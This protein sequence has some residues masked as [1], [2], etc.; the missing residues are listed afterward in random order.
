MASHN[1]PIEL[2]RFIGREREIADVRR[3]LAGVASGPRLLTLTGVGGSGKTRLA[4]RVAITLASSFP[5]GVWLVE[6]A[7]LTEP[8]L[9]A[10]ALAATLG[11]REQAG[12]EGQPPLAQT[13]AVA[14]APKQLLLVLDNCEHLAGACA[15]LVETLLQS[16]PDLRILATSREPLRVPGEVTWPVPPLALPPTD[17]PLP[18]EDLA[19]VESVALFVD[20]ARARRPSFTLTL[21]NAPAIIAICR[22]LEGL[23]LA[24]ELAAAQIGALPPEQLA[25]RLEDPPWAPLHL[26][27]GGRRTVPRHETLR[28]TL[29]WSHA[30]LTD[31]ERTVF[32]RLAV[33][34]GGFPLE[35][36]EFVCSA[37]GISPADVCGVLTSLVDKSLLIAL[38]Q[39]SIARFR[40]L[41]PVRQYAWEQLRRSGEEVAV[42]RRHA[43]AFL[44]LAEAAAPHLRSGGRGPWLARLEAEHDNLRAA[45]TWTLAAPGHPTVAPD[46]SGAPT[47]ADRALGVRLAAAL[48]HFWFFR[49]YFP[50]GVSWITQA[51]AQPADLAP[52]AR[53]KALCIG[54]ELVWMLF[55]PSVQCWEWL[56]ESVALWRTLGD[57]PGLAYALQASATVNPDSEHAEE[58]AREGLELS[59]TLHDLAG[60]ALALHAMGLLAL[61][62][63]DWAAAAAHLTAA[64]ALYRQVGDDWYGAQVLNNL[65]DVA[66]IQ[67]DDVQAAALYRE[68]LALF[69]SQGVRSAIPS[70][71]Q[72]LGYLTLRTGD[73]RR[74]R[75]LF[76]ESIGMFRDQAD[77]RGTAESLAGLAGTL[78]ALGRPARAAQ[79]F[80]AAAAML[81]ASGAELWP[82]NR[83]D[84]ERA[85]A[86]ARDQMSASDF[87]AAWAT[88][89]A[90]APDQAIMDALS[91]DLALDP[92]VTG[93]TE[94]SKPTGESVLT[95][96]EREV[97][98]LV[99]R[100][101]TNRQIAEELVITPG[102][103]TLH[104]KNI[105][106][107]LGFSSRAQ[108]AV[109][110]VERGLA[111][112]PDDT[113]D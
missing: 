53:A 100:G 36:A 94:A 83:P 7:A 78:A 109:W 59:R 51:V 19:Q 9:V 30:L 26:L 84:Y 17:R 89:R 3:L 93:A 62:R 16:C 28:A 80:G 111:A 82:A 91:E 92:T 12:P 25:A 108:I 31:I 72:N 65:G 97:V 77:R 18:L 102:T 44:A 1:L 66:R 4:R 47:P 50:E 49:G 57:G 33:F 32:R 37:E 70:V 40:L 54:G 81:E 87:A 29:D 8:G 52:T 13:L 104:V 58:N 76:R 22:H 11:V 74:A 67:G 6:L 68:S 79:L 2:S 39:D 60:M 10:R 90:L 24:L 38:T 48:G 112:E 103:A 64:L 15:D 86:L 14:L 101:R 56:A 61:Q 110:A 85:V 23:P 45:L 43:Q 99:A 69:R 105:L 46:R 34:S 95:P 63:R 27:T 41:E 20:R 96:R 73:A 55:G 71:L 107:K 106:R 75:A 42:R 35:A 88:G 21:A 5:D 98:R 113:Q